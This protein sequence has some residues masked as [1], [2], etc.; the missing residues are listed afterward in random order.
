[1]TVFLLVLMALHLEA[2]ARDGL[3]GGWMDVDGCKWIAKM[4]H[5]IIP[6][7]LEVCM[8]LPAFCLL[9]LSRLSPEQIDHVFL[10]GQNF[11]DGVRELLPALL[12]VRV[13][14]GLTGLSR[15]RSGLARLSD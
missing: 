15:G 8:S 9:G 6:L 14:F 11:Y 12:L 3:V 13:G 5:T 2:R 1:M 7:Y 4:D 10:F